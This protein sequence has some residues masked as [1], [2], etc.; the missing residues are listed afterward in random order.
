MPKEILQESK[1]EVMDKPVVD[2]KVI[3]FKQAHK[4]SG[5]SGLRFACLSTEIISVIDMGDHRVVASR[6]GY[7]VAVAEEFDDILALMKA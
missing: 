3:C 5:L 7:S 6:A 1:G 2:G 4:V